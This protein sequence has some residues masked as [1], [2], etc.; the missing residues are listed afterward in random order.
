MYRPTFEVVFVYDPEKKSLSVCYKG[1]KTTKCDLQEIFAREILVEP[2]PVL[3][4]DQKVFE[5]N[6]LKDRHFSFNPP[7]DSGIDEIRVKLL[8]LSLIGGGRYITLEANPSEAK[9][10]VYNLMDTILQTADSHESS[11]RM[12]ISL[13]NIVKAGFVVKYQPEKDGKP[14]N[15]QFTVSYPNTCNLKHEGKDAVL[16]QMLIDSGIGPRISEEDTV[17]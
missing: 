8:K 12:P 10:A 14:R 6:L 5:L 7:P 1:R 2:L 3:E 11:D 15:K 4:R 17:F 16:R 13:V 9:Q